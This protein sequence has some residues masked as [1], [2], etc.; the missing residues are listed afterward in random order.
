MQ[1]KCELRTSLRG[2]PRGLCYFFAVILL[3]LSSHPLRA[4]NP[5]EEYYDRNI[6]V[7]L[8]PSA[9]RVTYRMEISQVSLFSLPK[10]DERIQIGAVKGRAGLEAACMERFKVLIPDKLNG[11][12]NEKPLAWVVEKTY[13]SPVDSTHF[14]L[15]LRADW[16]PLAGDNKFEIVDGNFE[17]APGPYKLKIEVADEVDVSEVIEPRAWTDKGIDPKKDRHAIAVFQTSGPSSA[18]PPPQVEE[19]PAAPKL[20]IW[21]RL[22][23]DDL[24]ALLSTNYGLWLLVLIALVHGAGHSL[25]PGHGK[26][27]VAAYLVGERGTPWHA[28]MLGIVTTLTHTSAAIIVALLLQFLLPKGSENQVNRVLMFGCGMMMIFVGVWL[29]LQRLAGRSDHVHLFDMGHAHSHGEALP[30]T[31]SEKA[32]IVRLILLGIAGGIIPCWG[33]IMWVVGCIATGQFWMALPV[34]LAFSVGLA[35]VLILVGLSVVYA[36]RI[37]KNRW[38]ERRWF[39]RLFN[40]RTIRIMPVVGAAL[41]IAIGLFFCATSGIAAK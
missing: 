19:P 27:M 2:T 15:D 39:K 14:R 22:H 18:T 6:T 12:L 32:G 23:K 13:I 7:R 16:K 17:N 5:P 20:S 37:G 30:S 24:V 28:V 36:G 21:D 25:M 10:N 1:C 31:P 34:V 33:A 41:V 4:H 38:G 35:S 29:F 8:E 3:L 40:A 9:V 26:T 11:F